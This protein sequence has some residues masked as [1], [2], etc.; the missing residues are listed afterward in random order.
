MLAG[1][2]LCFGKGTNNEAEAQACLALLIRLEIIAHPTSHA[3]LH[4][5]LCLIIEFLTGAAKP[6][7]QSLHRAITRCK[8]IIKRLPCSLSFV[9]IP[10]KENA[11]TDWL[12]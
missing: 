10:R 9:H 8:A 3:V 12:A 2:S 1:S 6:G 11:L 4:G 7:K 5:V